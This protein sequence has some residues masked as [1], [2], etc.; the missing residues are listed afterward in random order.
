MINLILTFTLD[1]IHLYNKSGITLSLVNINSN[2][3][4]K[5]ESNDY[6]NTDE[7]SVIKIKNHKQNI[8]S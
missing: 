8:E 3:T 7:I 1:L 4:C 5:I 2:N 6:N